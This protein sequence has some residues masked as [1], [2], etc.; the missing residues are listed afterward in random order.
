MFCFVFYLFLTL[1]TLHCSTQAFSTCGEQGGL[2]ST[3]SAQPS[4]CDGFSCC[5]AQA[6][7]HRLQQLWHTGLVA[8]QHV[9]SS[10]TRD[11]TCVPCTGR[12]ILNHWTTREVQPLSF[13]QHEFSKTNIHTSVGVERGRRGKG[14]EEE[15]CPTGNKA[16]KLIPQWILQSPRDTVLKNHEP[17]VQNDLVPV[18]ARLGCDQLLEIPAGVSSPVFMADLLPQVVVAANLNHPG[19]SSNR[20]ELADATAS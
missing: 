5:A 16:P 11:Q 12:Q 3:C 18:G 20:L 14:R 7:G 8:P 9:G 19:W 15:F 4:H 17:L 2:L 10:Q 13:Y 1:L 6:L